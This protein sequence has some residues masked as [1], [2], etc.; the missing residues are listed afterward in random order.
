MQVDCRRAAGPFQAHGH[1]L[2]IPSPPEALCVN[3]AA[4]VA[5]GSSNRFPVGAGP[6]MADGANLHLPPPVYHRRHGAVCRK[7]KALDLAFNDRQIARDGLRRGEALSSAAACARSRSASFAA[8]SRTCRITPVAAK[9]T[10][11]FSDFA[12]I[13]TSGKPY[14]SACRHTCYGRKGESR[15]KPIYSDACDKSPIRV[16]LSEAQRS[17]ES[18][19]ALA[20]NALKDS[21]LRSE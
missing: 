8:A 19:N 11:V 16:I 4:H 6:D 20:S 15:G 2:A 17:E 1:G 13:E 18:F 9:A 12:I 21:S 7:M 5:C 14:M 10:I 3:E